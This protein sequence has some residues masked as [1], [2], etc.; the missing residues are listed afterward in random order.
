MSAFDA[1]AVAACKSVMIEVLTIL[2][3]HREHLVVVGGWVPPLLFGQ[4]DHVGS[5]DVD[6]A[7][8]WRRVPNHVY[9]TIR[10]ELVARGYYRVDDDPDNRY[11]RDVNRDGQPFTVRVDFLTGLA[12][13]DEL[14]PSTRIMQGMVVWCAPGVRVALDHCVEKELSGNLP[15][16]GVNNIS[17][18]RVASAGAL[19]V[20]KGLALADRMKEKDAYDIY[21]CCVH[22][23]DGIAGLA[24]EIRGLLD[25]PEA[26]K[27]VDELQRKFAGLDSVGPVWAASVVQS[28]GGDFELAQ[29][30]TY[31]RVQALLGLI[32][33]S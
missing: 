20:M 24:Q 5:L 13:G 4:G 6:F 10:S 15:E 28:D 31:E 27:A 29:R 3:K 33:K 12:P 19:L 17:G 8:D 9:E 22:H 1:A 2:G 16:G 30:E 25:D 23:P 11:R 7:I 14:A 26:I 21:Y 32:R 18:V